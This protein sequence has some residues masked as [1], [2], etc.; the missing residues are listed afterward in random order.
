M[1][2]TQRTRGRRP[3]P[4]CRID[5]PSLLMAMV[6]MNMDADELARAAGIT[7]PTVRR[8]IAGGSTTARSIA[9]ALATALD[10]EVDKLVIQ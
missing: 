3:G 6:A 4:T 7:L 5:P 10:V 2:P 9:E 1:D 8:L